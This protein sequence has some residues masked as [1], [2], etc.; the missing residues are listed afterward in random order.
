MGGQVKSSRIFYLHSLDSKN[1][2]ASASLFREHLLMLL[3]T[4]LR[5]VHLDELVSHAPFDMSRGHFALTFDDGYADNVDIALPVLLELGIPAT[6]F[7]VTGCVGLSRQSS[8]AGN[9]LLQ[10]KEMASRG[11]L[12]KWISSGMRLGS[13]TK[14]HKNSARSAEIN[15]ESFVGELRESREMLEEVAGEAVLDFCYPN[16]QRG[17]FSELSR[18]AVSAAGFRRACTTIFGSARHFHDPLALPRCGINVGDSPRDT[19]SRARGLQDF[20]RLVHLNRQGVRKWGNG[21]SSLDT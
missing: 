2:E 6:L 18:E 10:K 20:R 12:G 3:S 14:Y 7:V 13:H 15:F 4:G 21:R 5:P 17:A 16:G 19:R 11:D 9:L 8:S 1:P